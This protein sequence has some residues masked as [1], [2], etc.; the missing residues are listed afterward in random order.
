M[1]SI[2]VVEGDKVIVAEAYAGV[3]QRFEALQEHLGRKL[4]LTDLV[5]TYH[6]IDHISKHRSGWYSNELWLFHKTSKHRSGAHIKTSTLVQ[7]VYLK[8][9]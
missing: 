2:L 1:H 8:W 5:V 7:A 6:H 9:I 3:A 4:I